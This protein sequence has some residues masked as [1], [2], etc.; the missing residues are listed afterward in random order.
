MKATASSS[1][2][3]M[4]ILASSAGS[5]FRLARHALEEAAAEDAEADGRAERAQAEDDAD[6]KYGHTFN[7]CNVFHSTLLEKTVLRRKS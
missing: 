6:G 4:N 5:E 7:V 2:A 3:T 1:A